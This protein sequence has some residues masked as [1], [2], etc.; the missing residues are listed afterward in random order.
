MFFAILAVS[1]QAAM[2][3]YGV[4]LFGVALVMQGDDVGSQFVQ[5]DTANLACRSAEIGGYQVTAKSD[6][7]KKAG[8]AIASDG[9]DA[10]LAHYLEQAFADGFDVVLASRGIVQLQFFPFHQFINDG[11]SHVGING[12]CAVAQ[13]EGGVHDFTHFT[14][15]NN[16]GSLYALLHRDKVMMNGTDGEQGRDG[17]VRFIH[18]PVA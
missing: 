3:K 17:S 16:Q 9:A 2:F 8:T 1:V 6:G 15:F 12:T 14:G 4:G 11:E 13:Q 18:I 10:H 7:F 5:T